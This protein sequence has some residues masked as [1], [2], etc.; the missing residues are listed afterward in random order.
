MTDLD[1]LCESLVSVRAG[2]GEAISCSLPEILE[3][4]GQGADLD[5]PNLQPHQQHAWHAFL[6]QLAALALDEAGDPALERSAEDWRGLLLRLAGGE[7]T[8]FRLVCDDPSKPAFFQPPVPEGSFAALKNSAAT[9]EALDLL[10][11]A[12][13][14]DIKSERIAA[15]PAELFLFALVTLQTMEG[16]MGRGNYGIARMNGG[17]ASRPCFAVVAPTDAANRFRRDVQLLLAGLEPSREGLGFAAAGG[18][19]LLWLLPWTG[20]DSLALSSLHPFF[21][22]I[23]R[24]VRLLADAKGRIEV[25]F[26][27][28]EAPRVDAKERK[29]VLGDL[30]TPIKIAD[31]AALTVGEAGFNYRL[32]TSL[33]FTPDDWEPAAAAALPAGGR[34][35]VLAQVLVRGQGKTAG[36]HERRVPIP[37]RRLHRKDAR[38]AA[39]A[40]AKTR[41]VLVAEV[42]KKVLR[43]AICA[44]LQGAPEDLKFNDPGAR[45]H[46]DRLDA[47]VDRIFFEEL[48]RD[49][50]EDDL[51]VRDRRWQKTL[52]KLAEAIFEGAVDAVPIPDARRY[53]AIAAGERLLNGGLRKV[54]P[55]AY[56]ETSNLEESLPA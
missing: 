12:K 40:L 41:R 43:P 27:A 26:V 19:R 30:W 38:D 15:A 23:C 36:F 1:F 39:G 54:L 37:P 8:A 53:R 33:L 28:S 17:F 7:A 44:L 47:E 11:T 49:L 13:N 25:R 24:R 50:E 45:P 22:E 4:L 6:V 18:H 51:H 56:A 10:V 20:R 32:L 46:V 2:E 42:Q 29:G 3:L 9:P 5:F 34:A 21:L 35:E 52:R 31:Q 16:F 14:H 48:F 55:A